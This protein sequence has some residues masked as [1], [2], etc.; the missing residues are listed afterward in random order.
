MKASI[1]VVLSSVILLAGGAASWSKTALSP[2]ASH[3]APTGA[4]SHDGY[5][6]SVKLRI[7]AWR[8][9]FADLGA[10]A[11]GATSAAEKAPRPT[12][13]R[14]GRV[15]NGRQTGSTRQ[16]RPAGLRPRP[17]TSGPPRTWTRPGPSSSRPRLSCGRAGPEVER[18]I[19][20]WNGALIPCMPACVYCIG[21]SAAEFGHQ[22][23]AP[24]VALVVS[25]VGKLDL[26]RKCN[27]QLAGVG[28]ATCSAARRTRYGNSGRR[29]RPQASARR[30]QRAM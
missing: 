10:R 29:G 1:I 18:N 4:V 7:G 24:I 30:S 19:A 2:A 28:V 11:S 5:L 21:L 25:T 12:S 15:S 22:R 9:K 16:A 17:P 26:R 14:P 20:A 8:A 3:D 27:A 23:K 6:Q 13:P